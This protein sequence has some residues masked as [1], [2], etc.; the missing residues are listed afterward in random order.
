M[1]LR[2]SIQKTRNFFNKNLQNLKILLLGGYV[3][4]SKSTSFKSFS[5]GSKNQSSNHQTERYCV[6]V[7][8]EWVSDHQVKDIKETDNSVVVSKLGA[9]RNA[10]SSNKLV[11]S[12]PRKKEY[13][14]KEEKNKKD[15]KIRK[16]EQCSKSM[17]ELAKRMK[18][19]E[20]MDA[21][22]M[23]HVLDVEEALHYYSRLKSPV[24]VDIVDNFFMNMYTE[25]YVPKASASIN[26]S[27]R[28]LGSM[29]L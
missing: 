23:E 17:N 22:D 15:S 19:L 3:K 11:K 18:E 7:C 6:D 16:G 20:M 28:R 24:Y 9:S 25:L 4:L 29:R 13:G 5:C 8:E 21:S 10:E 27:K 26:N 14:V 12:P 1:Q 2:D